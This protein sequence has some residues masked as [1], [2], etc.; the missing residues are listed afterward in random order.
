MACCWPWWR[1]GKWDVDRFS[2]KQN[3]TGLAAEKLTAA[4]SYAVCG[5]MYVYVYTYLPVF[6]CIYINTFTGRLPML[7]IILVANWLTYTIQFSANYFLMGVRWMEDFLTLSALPLPGVSNRNNF[8]KQLI[9]CQQMRQSIG[10]HISNR[11]RNWNF[12]NF[13]K[14]MTAVAKYGIFAQH[15]SLLYP[16]LVE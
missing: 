13:I 5:C 4:V 15:S 1:E 9:A 14:V 11:T 8:S 12:A 6:K 10:F 7:A 2:W 3:C 16:L